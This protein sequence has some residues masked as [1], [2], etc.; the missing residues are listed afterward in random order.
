P[1]V[2]AGGRAA[3][4][5]PAAADKAPDAL[6]PGRGADVFDHDIDTVAVGEILDLRD[7]ILG[8]VI[9]D[10]I[11]AELPRPGEFLVA[12]GGRKHASAVPPGDLDRRLPDAAP[13]A[14]HEHVL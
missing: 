3:R 10:F 14:E 5:E 2:V 12:A 9:D 13:G 1:G 6:V 8:A 7:H 4:D 11:R